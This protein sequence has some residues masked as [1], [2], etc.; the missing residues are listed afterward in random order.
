MIASDMVKKLTRR[1][2]SLALRYD[3]QTMS[4]YLLPHSLF[5]QLLSYQISAY[6]QEPLIAV[7]PL[8]A[9]L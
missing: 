5:A 6:F 2:P 3:Y 9:D 1:K 4:I 7:E 8:Q